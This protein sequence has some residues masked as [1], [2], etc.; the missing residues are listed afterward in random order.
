MSTVN[1]Q[2]K[3]IAIT[4]ASS[5]IG[6][7]TAI[8]CAKAGMNVALFARR[9][10][11]LAHVAEL[12]R[13]AG[14]KSTRVIAV[15]GDVSDPEACKQLVDLSIE[16]FGSLYSVYANA[17]YGF[18]KPMHETSEAELRQI[19][20]VNFF[21]TMN[22]V[23]PAM[24]HMLSRPFEGNARKA[25][26]GH[27]LICSSCLAKITLPRYGAYSATKAAQNHIG[28]AMRHELD[29]KGVAVSTVHPISTTTEFFDIVKQRTGKELQTHT[30]GLFVQPADTVAK[31]TVCC[32]RK[33]HAE[34]WTGVRG[35]ITRLGMSTLTLL[36]ALPDLMFRGMAT[37][38]DRGHR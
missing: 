38:S 1:L 24:E 25:P 8:A 4:G 26:R 3:A 11:K 14:G 12:C 29:G 10:D 27:I 23:R 22:T 19:F 13:Q 6:A 21:G 32:L 16:A 7:A 30:P 33:P 2:G 36:P 34:V 15:E 35:A 9:A 20:E 5:G 17:G 31:H 37:G 18:E 28:R